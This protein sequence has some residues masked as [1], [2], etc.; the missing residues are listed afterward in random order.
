MSK[1]CALRCWGRGPA[2][3]P[4]VRGRSWT[5]VTLLNQHISYLPCPASF[6]NV[7]QFYLTYLR[8]VTCL[9]RIESR[10]IWIIGL[11]LHSYYCVINVNNGLNILKSLWFGALMWLNCYSITLLFLRQSRGTLFVRY[12]RLITY[13]VVTLRFSLF[14]NRYEVNIQYFSTHSIQIH[15]LHNPEILYTFSPKYYFL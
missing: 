4:E 10:P 8:H 14:V 11:A 12:S 5:S 2:N 15:T 6:M 3:R 7:V 9:A 13:A 1:C